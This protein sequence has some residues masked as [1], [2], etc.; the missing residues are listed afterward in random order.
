MSS[1]WLAFFYGIKMFQYM[2]L[3]WGQVKGSDVLVVGAGTYR[4]KVLANR[5][6]VAGMEQQF[7]VM[8]I[9]ATTNHKNAEIK[10][11]QYDIDNS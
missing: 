4:G 2:P 3:H 1:V 8:R 5:S 9:P 11:V 6:C 10:N 7:F